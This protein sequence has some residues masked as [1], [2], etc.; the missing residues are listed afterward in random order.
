[1]KHLKYLLLCL[2]FAAIVT[3]CGS[4]DQNGHKK[5]IRMSVRQIDV[6]E[7]DDYAYTIDFFAPDSTS[8]EAFE[9]CIKLPANSKPMWSHVNN[10]RVHRVMLTFEGED[11]EREEIVTSP[12]SE[13]RLKI[14]SSRTLSVL[15]ARVPYQLQ[16]R[17]IEITFSKKLD[18]KQ[19]MRGLAVIEDNASGQIRVDGNKLYLYPDRNAEGVV[20][21]RLSGNIRSASGVTL[22]ED[23]SLEVSLESEK[24]N[25]AFARSGNILPSDGSA[26]IPIKA[27]MMKG[28]RVRVF[29]IYSDNIGDM[30]T[31]ENYDDA[32]SL[33]YNGRPVAV[34]TI[35]FDEETSDFS[36]WRNYGIDISKLVETEP[37]AMYRVEMLL[38]RRLSAWPCDTLPKASRETFEIEDRNILRELQS[39]F[40]KRGYYWTGEG[41]NNY[42]EWYDGWYEDSQ[43][44]AAEP[45]YEEKKYGQ[46]FLSTNIG[47]A[48]LGEKSG[49]IRVI[50]NSILDA[51]PMSGI[52]V[53]AYS[54]QRRVCGTATTNSDGIADISVDASLGRPFYVVATDG[55]DCTYLRVSQGE[56][57]ST[58]T[59]DVGGEQVQEGLKGY[60]YGDRGVWRPGDVINIGFM[61][62]D[63]D[64]T[65]PKNHPVSIEVTNARGQIHFRKTVTES[66]LGTYAFN[67][68]TDEE[69]PTGIWNAKISVGGAVFTKNLRVET[70][71][72]NRLKIDVGAPMIIK[73]SGSQ[74]GIHTEWLNGNV[75][76]NLNFDMTATMVPTKTQ[77]EGYGD[78]VF[79]DITK[80]EC[81]AEAE[82]AHGKTDAEGNAEVYVSAIDEISQI[83]PGMLSCALTTRAYEPSGE[84][85]TDVMYLKCSPY[86]RY[87]G[88][89]SPQKDNKALATGQNHT[90]NIVCVDENGKPQKNV[91]LTAN[92]Y[93]AEWYWWWNSD[94]SYIA[95]YTTSGYN[96]PVKTLSITTDANGKGTIS[97]KM[98]D[99][100]WGT[101]LISVGE[102]YGHSSCIMAYFDWPSMGNRNADGRETSTTL[103]ITTDKTSYAPGDMIN[104]GM[105]SAKGSRAIVSICNGSRIVTTES[106][107]CTGEQTSVKIKATN[108]M[109]PNAYVCVQLIQPYAQTD[110][111]MPLRLY[112]VKPIEVNEAKSHLNP[113]ITMKDEVRPEST[114]EVSVSEKNGRAM[115]YTIAIVDEG[116]LDLTRFKTPNPWAAMNAKEALGVR[117]WDM[118]SLV[119]GAYGGCIEQMFS[120]GG[121]EALNGGPKAIV[122]RFTPMVWFEG[123]FELGKGKT[124]KHKVEI[125]NYNGRVR[126]M[127]V[128]GDGMAYGNTDKSVTVRKPLMLTG[129]MP[130]IIGAGDE[131][132]VSAT[133]FATEDNLGEVKVNISCDGDAQIIGSK[134]QSIVMKKKGDQTIAFALK[135][136][137]KGGK[138]QIALDAKSSN[139]K[140]SYVVETDIR[141][142]ETTLAESETAVIE[143]GKK[144]QSKIQ[145][146]G[147]SNQKMLL[148]VSAAYP[149]NVASRIAELIQYPHGCAEQTTSKAFAQLY[150][151]DFADLSDEQ[152]AET[153]ENIKRAIEKLRTH[154][155]PRGGIAYWQ[156]QTYD[157][158][159]CSAYVMQFLCEA[160]QKGYY[161]EGQ[162][163]NS[164]ANYLLE[165][166]R[167]WR[168]TDHPSTINN[169]AFAIY[170]LALSGNAD[171]SAMN[172]MMQMLN[173]EE[174]KAKITS[175]TAT[176][177]AAA[178]AAYPLPDQASNLIAVAIEK[179]NDGDRYSDLYT[180]PMRLS[181]MAAINPTLPSAKV[182]ADNIAKRLNSRAWLSTRETALSIAAEAHYLKKIKASGK[183]KFNVASDKTE[184]VETTKLAWNAETGKNV[185]LTNNGDGVLFV[186]FTASGTARQGDVAASSN[187]LAVNVSY[188]ALNGTPIDV[189]NIA[190]STLFRAEVTV[191]NTSE[192][193]VENIA[194]TQVLPSGWEIIDTKNSSAVSYQDIRDDRLLTYINKLG[195]GQE[196]RVI[197]GLSAT[198]AGHF[199]VPAIAAEAMYDATTCGN[200]ASSTTETR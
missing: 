45:Y 69:D 159:W 10:G 194:L 92:I 185:T 169:A 95:N 193:E 13:L 73:N 163:K 24:P 199:Y 52:E 196:C 128:A 184:N 190:Q 20:T 14:P 32:S 111:D 165:V 86:M 179:Q 80:S 135:A 3:A 157:N 48:S 151:S 56:E 154:Q 108:E 173:N 125:P 67:V 200:T 19:N 115:S 7:N 139:D 121:D 51:K 122:N 15:T 33:R 104:I 172:R 112:G 23:S 191:R 110:N 36:Q 91:H 150:L 27:I 141:I 109:M 131:V 90:F 161:I 106:L 138:V 39:Y 158:Q 70:I 118:Y 189:T 145:P 117:L 42:T 94:N 59:F 72:P 66:K 130:R 63:K 53:K 1:M 96:R 124:A 166:A 22:G 37:G 188:S 29:R 152:A 160:E 180:L 192:T 186:T 174:T 31:S 61:L 38:D 17:C 177:L 83:A 127:V 142:A 64:Q 60:V 103:S 40:D 50:C 197:V 30:L 98:N 176:L 78:Y 107:E 41:T 156:G 25:V 183:M 4:D 146:V 167:G 62:C 57:L 187:G 144:W 114:C 76:R 16:E 119:C 75:A 126:V 55:H 58:S 198:Y 155:T 148:E 120:I 123:P 34:T 149:L 153:Q 46:N 116:L 171:L 18:G 101:Y 100:E 170:S 88:I 12:D 99:S 21:V 5:M 71:K 68:P 147:E 28:V 81:R 137:N 85:S 102:N 44:P 84:F 178:Y 49:N 54:L 168:S 143:P 136:G 140:A 162:F 89:A 74:L 11:N 77:F 82:V 47:I 195:V 132:S 105:P 97:L 2:G 133:V 181:A 113:V 6:I 8:G 26:V 182:I 43:N 9:R 175:E 79:D 35:F 134:T 93:K 129:T 87:V 65:L 164:L